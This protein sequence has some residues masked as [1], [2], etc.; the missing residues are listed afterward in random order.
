[1]VFYTNQLLRNIESKESPAIK[2]NTAKLYGDA[3]VWTVVFID[4]LDLFELVY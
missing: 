2:K 3:L 1:M 4:W